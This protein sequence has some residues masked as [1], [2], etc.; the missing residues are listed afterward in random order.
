[1]VI[2]LCK[3]VCVVGGG[4]LLFDIVCIDGYMIS[5]KNMKVVLEVRVD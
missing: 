2:K 3:I 1:M 5:L 4:Y